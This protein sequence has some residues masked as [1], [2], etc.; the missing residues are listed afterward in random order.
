MI[1][2]PAAEQ[3]SFVYDA[4][5]SYSRRDSDSAEE[6]ERELERFRLPRAVRHRLGRRHLN[7]F[8]DVTDITGNRLDRVLDENLTRSHKL[9]VLCSPNSRGSE[10]VGREIEQFAVL[11]YP[12]GI[13]PV[14]IAGEPNDRDEQAANWAFPDALGKVLDGTPLATDLRPPAAPVVTR[15]PH[16]LTAS[17]EWIRLVSNL[18]DLAPDDLTQRLARDRNRR[19]RAGFSI[20]AV[21]VVALAALLAWALQESQEATRQRDRAQEQA[22]LATSRLLA[23]TAQNLSPTESDLALGLALAADNTSRTPQSA[24]ALLTTLSRNPQLIR[25]LHGFTAFSGAIDVS[26]DDERAVGGGSDGRLVQWRLS[27]GTSVVLSEGGERIEAVAYTPTGETILVLRQDIVGDANAVE[28]WDVATGEL[29]AQRSFGAAVVNDLL[30]LDESTAIVVGGAEGSGLADAPGVLSRWRWSTDDVRHIPIRRAI[31]HIARGEAGVLVAVGSFPD[32]NEI[33]MVDP[34]TGREISTP[35]ALGDQSVSDLDTRADGTAV[36]AVGTE[37]LLIDT[38][39]GEVTGR[40]ALDRSAFAAQFVGAGETLALWQSSAAP[41]TDG[42]AIHL[43]DVRTLQ[44]VGPKIPTSG[45]VRGL[46]ALHE[47]EVVLAVRERGGAAVWDVSRRWFNATGGMGRVVAETGFPPSDTAFTSDGALAISTGPRATVVARNT[48]S[49]V[50]LWRQDVLPD[51]EYVSAAAISPDGGTTAIAGGAFV[52]PG[53]GVVVM[54][55]TRSGRVIAEEE[56]GASQLGHV[57]FS[58]DGRFLIVGTGGLS[59]GAGTVLALEIGTERR[60]ELDDLRPRDLAFVGD[61]LVWTSGMG[62]IRS[63]NMD[64]IVSGERPVVIDV[65]ESVSSIEPTGRPGQVAVAAETQVGVLEL[66]DDEPQIAWFGDHRDNVSS[67]TANPTGTTLASTDY[68]GEL[69]FWDLSSGLAVTGPVLMGTS[70]GLDA[71]YSPRSGSSD[72]L[73]ISWAGLRTVDGDPASWVARACGIVNRELTR[74]E[75]DRFVGAGR[76]QVASCPSD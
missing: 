38:T 33:V 59:I 75:W 51:G 36:A 9:V 72:L 47:S 48:V 76:V 39:D 73:L 46:A 67:V 7:V 26:P 3:S 19:L 50:E 16:R 40:F 35:H 49:G 23:G 28:A 12:D 10:Y 56:V 55:D 30:A 70:E 11:R 44:E 54:L 18:V 62:D 25:Y 57:A 20:L 74:A 5:I 61:R 37:A 64:A 41:A 6:I 1:D 66:D 31:S 15:T 8:R 21:V 22:D 68:S 27:T 45:V 52:S 71:I 13:V 69:V 53:R 29:L 17:R 14:L 24:E 34:M 63:T 32:I 58:P 2:G 42:P 60:F 43:Y 65:D 4:F